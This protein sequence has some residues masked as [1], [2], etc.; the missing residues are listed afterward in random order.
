MGTAGHRGYGLPM[1]SASAQFVVIG[2][3]N[4][5]GYHP[6][7]CLASQ[8]AWAKAHHV[9]TAAYAMTTYPTT[10]QLATYGL[11][12]PYEGTGLATRLAN[13]GYAQA[14]FNV[15]SMR[16]AELVSPIVWVD[17]EPTSIAPWTKNIA[18]N[19]AVIDG[20]LRGYQAAGFKVGIYSN[21]IG[22]RKILGSTRYGLPEWRT[23]GPR[24]RDSIRSWSPCS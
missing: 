5:V 20:V 4:G 13:A 24:C 9:Y 19:K 15:A 2:L 8:V 6:N 1:P 12:G 16:R 17:V 22:Y 23:A 10:R 7:Q 11:K 18:A 3:T 21:R 14:L